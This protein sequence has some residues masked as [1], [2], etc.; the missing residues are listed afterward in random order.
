MIIAIDPSYVKSVGIA[1]KKGEKIYKA[2]VFIGDIKRD[3]N[4]TLFLIE[5]G[6]RILEFIKTI[7]ENEKEII[8]AIEGQWFGKNPKVAMGLIELR[9]IIQGMLISLYPNVELYTISPKLW[10]HEILNIKNLKSEEI[11]KVSK[12]YAFDLL[13]EEVSDDE[14]DAICILKFVENKIKLN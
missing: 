8:V 14:A 10:Q 11:K 6:K 5:I 4:L 13:N 1:W 7:C 12:K 9:G 2:S 3:E